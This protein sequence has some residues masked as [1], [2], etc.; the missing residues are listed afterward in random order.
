MARVAR[1]ALIAESE[2]PRRLQRA[3]LVRELALLT[4]WTGVLDAHTDPIT[5]LRAMQNGTRLITGSADRTARVWDLTTGALLSTLT[6]PAG[7][8]KSVEV[9]PGGA[10]AAI[11]WRLGRTVRI[12]DPAT[13]G[14]VNTLQLGFAP[15]AVAMSILAD[16]TP[17]VVVVEAIS[18]SA[19][20]AVTGALL[21]KRTIRGMMGVE[22]TE[23]AGDGAVVGSRGNA[24]WLW[25][26]GTEVGHEL[27]AH[28]TRVSMLRLTRDDRYAISGAQDGE[29]LVWDLLTGQ[30]RVFQGHTGTIRAAEVTLDAAHLVTVSEDGTAR[31]WNFATDALVSGPL[32]TLDHTNGVGSVAVTPDGDIVTGQDNGEVR[33]WDLETGAHLHTMP[34]GDA[35]L[36]SIVTRVTATPD[37]R[38]IRGRWGGTVHVQTP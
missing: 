1:R 11:T 20:N 2:E 13:G 3:Q 34:G 36:G 10:L 28:T 35:Q 24:V 33:T 18:A 8:V 23:V 32:H 16:G 4:R 9:A 37:G 26:A 30:P 7:F 5:A 15:S 38:V 6:D 14:V 21:G 22:N 19:F 29:V 31:V 17:T 25:P 12:V 27:G